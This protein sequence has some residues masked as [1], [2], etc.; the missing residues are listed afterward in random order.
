[1]NDSISAIEQQTSMTITVQPCSQIAV[2]GVH[3]ARYTTR[4]TIGNN[5]KPTYRMALVTQ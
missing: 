3:S 2:Q 1:M 4:A 5:I